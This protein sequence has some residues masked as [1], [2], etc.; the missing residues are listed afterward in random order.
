MQLLIHCVSARPP[1]RSR[2]RVQ[3]RWRGPRVGSDFISLIGPKKN[4]VRSHGWCRKCFICRTTRLAQSP[5]S[6]GLFVPFSLMENFTLKNVTHSW[7]PV[8]I[9][10]GTFHFHC[11]LPRDQGLPRISDGITQQDLSLF[12]KK[13]LFSL[14]MRSIDCVAIRHI[15]TPGVHSNHVTLAKG[16]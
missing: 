10:M 1:V 15:I 11:Q 2:A 7:V 9:V 4:P 14:H 8:D 13:L 5:N 12:L 3:F 6:P 16:A